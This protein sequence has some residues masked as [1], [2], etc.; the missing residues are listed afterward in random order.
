[1][2]AGHPA[3]KI[4]DAA[5]NTSYKRQSGNNLPQ[6]IGNNLPQ[7]MIMKAKQP[8]P[9]EFCI[10]TIRHSDKLEQW[11]QDGGTGK[12]TENRKWI[13]ALELL[14]R[15][16]KANEQLPLIFAAAES[17]SGLI[18]WGVIT[19]LR[20]GLSTKPDS[21]TISFTGLKPIRGKPRRLSS[22]RLRSTR[23][24][25]SDNFIRP[26]AICYTPN[27]LRE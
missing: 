12:F 17:V 8:P 27:F 11:C 18:Y 21:T 22:L 4:V 3:R 1:M 26:Y 7:R 2:R 20:P 5:K 16:E 25:L 19:N 23:K 6:P 14:E 13:T 15:A 9:S 24:Q 10:Y